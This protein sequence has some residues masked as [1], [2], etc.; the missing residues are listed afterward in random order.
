MLTRS[1]IESVVLSA[2]NN[3]NRERADAPPVR[4]ARDTPLFGSA[5]ELDSLSLVS[6]IVDVET[7]LNDEHGCDLSLMDDRALS[8]PASPFKDVSSL[9]DYIIELTSSGA[10]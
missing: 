1:V 4:V 3:L 7:T 6:V 2:L 10:R 9:T 5:S 8:R